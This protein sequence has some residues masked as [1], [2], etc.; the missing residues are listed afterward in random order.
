[1]RF[2]GVYLTLGCDVMYL[3]CG[4]VL[5]LVYVWLLWCDV[6][7]YC[8]MGCVMVWLAGLLGLLLPGGCVLR[9]RVG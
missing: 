6:Y 4:L 8:Y 2:A 1:M 9:F 3:L 7:W 5:I